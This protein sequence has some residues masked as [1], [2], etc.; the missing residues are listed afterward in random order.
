MT[1][2]ALLPESGEMDQVC[3]FDVGCAT[4]REETID[5]GAAAGHGGVERPFAVK[6]L[7]AGVYGRVL[8]KNTVL[9]LIVYNIPPCFH[10]LQHRFAQVGGGGGRRDVAVGFGG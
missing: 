3:T 9:K 8:W 6:L 7:L 5:S 10:R 1:V 2:H 4:F